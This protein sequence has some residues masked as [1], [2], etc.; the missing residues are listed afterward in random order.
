MYI[1]WVWFT[2]VVNLQ[3]SINVENIIH[4]STNDSTVYRTLSI[5]V[6]IGNEDCIV[7]VLG[8]S[9]TFAGLQ[10][11]AVVVEITNYNSSSK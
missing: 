5:E 10:H 4:Y 8:F 7:I 3:I 9:Y 6:M 1:V 11:P 2:N